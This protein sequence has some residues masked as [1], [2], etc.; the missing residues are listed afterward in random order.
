MMK[1]LSRPSRHYLESALV[2]WELVTET[3]L[4]RQ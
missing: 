4:Q 2:K 1:L 3:V